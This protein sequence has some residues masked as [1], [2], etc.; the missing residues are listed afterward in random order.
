MMAGAACACT[1][2]H[3]SELPGSDWPWDAC[4]RE[5][6]ACSCTADLSCQAPDMP[7][8][9]EVPPARGHQGWQRLSAHPQ[10]AVS[11][12]TWPWEAWDRAQSA[13]S[14][15]AAPS[16]LAPGGPLLPRSACEGRPVVAKATW[17]HMAC[18]K[19]PESECS[20]AARLV[21]H[22]AGHPCQYCLRHQVAYVQCTPQCCRTSD[23]TKLCNHG[24]HM[25]SQSRLPQSE[26]GLTHLQQCQLVWC[27]VICSIHVAHI[28]SIAA[29]GQLWGGAVSERE[30]A[31][32]HR[33]CQ[34]PPGTYKW[35]CSMFSAQTSSPAKCWTGAGVITLH[36]AS[37]RD[38]MQHVL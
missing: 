31:C 8:S 15:T 17:I 36:T 18:S 33:A 30:S 20:A 38:S 14:C 13:C 7:P 3:V 21:R 16:C 34:S 2:S 10:H 12:S 4:V 22:L 23:D 37:Y 29:K 25:I 24:W 6:D 9:P 1:G 5:Q 19:T 11:F 26:E 32:S 27:P 28:D 35:G